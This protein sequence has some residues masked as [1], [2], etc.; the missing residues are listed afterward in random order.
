MVCVL[1][2]RKQ[3]VIAARPNS[4]LARASSESNAPSATPLKPESRWRRSPSRPGRTLDGLDGLDHEMDQCLAN[5]DLDRPAPACQWWRCRRSSAWP[6][7]RRALAAEASGQARRTDPGNVINRVA[8][9]GVL[10]A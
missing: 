5:A 10:R 2:P 1:A 3:L 6:G 8:T 9:A 7:S 4:A